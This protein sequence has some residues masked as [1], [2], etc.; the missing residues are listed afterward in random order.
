MSGCC[1]GWPEPGQAQSDQAGGRKEG[2][3]KR[4]GGRE[5]ERENVCMCIHT[6]VQI[7]KHPKGHMQSVYCYTVTGAA[8]NTRTKS[9]L[10]IHSL[11]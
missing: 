7:L 2:E 4:E 10:I 1:P 6:R 5:G 3:R 8:V 9:N 11:H